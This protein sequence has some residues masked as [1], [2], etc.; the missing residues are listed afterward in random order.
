MKDAVTVSSGTKINSLGEPTA[1]A[2]ASTIRCSS[3]EHALPQSNRAA[4]ATE[5]RC[6]A[7]G[8]S[9]NIVTNSDRF[10]THNLKNT[11]WK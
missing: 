5:M 6:F 1:L 7:S 9:L 8:V 11:T 10:D 4:C 3:V 2:W